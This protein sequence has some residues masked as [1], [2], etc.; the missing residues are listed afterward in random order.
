ME[1][2]GGSLSYHAFSCVEIQEPESHGF[3]SCGQEVC[4]LVSCRSTESDFFASQ[5]RL[6]KL[7]GI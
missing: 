5:F 1:I 3:Y 7:G 6:K 4:T 2:G